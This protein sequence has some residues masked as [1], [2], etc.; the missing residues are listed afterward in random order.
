MDQQKDDLEKQLKQNEIKAYEQDANGPEHEQHSSIYKIVLIVLLVLMACISLTCIYFYF[1]NKGAEGAQGQA[2]LVERFRGIYDTVTGAAQAAENQ[3][4]DAP[5]PP[6]EQMEETISDT[7]AKMSFQ[8]KATFGVLAVIIVLLLIGVVVAVGV[9][10]GR[11]TPE[12]TKPAKPTASKP[13]NSTKPTKDRPTTTPKVEIPNDPINISVPSTFQEYLLWT[14]LIVYYLIALFISLYGAVKGEPLWGMTLVGWLLVLVP[15]VLVFKF[16]CKKLLELQLT[17]AQVLISTRNP[18]LCGVGKNRNQ[19]GFRVFMSCVYSLAC[20]LMLP[21]M[22]VYLVLMASREV[23]LKLATLI[24]Q[25]Q[26][27]D[28]AGFGEAFDDVSQFFKIGYK[29]FTNGS[30]GHVMRALSRF[31]KAEFREMAKRQANPNTPRI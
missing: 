7:F 26:L 31:P 29:A 3:M 28:K 1:G 23:A 15:I 21:F 9:M 30:H 24:S 11:Q 13:K 14:A 4:D 12:Y 5:P 19:R 16:L 22:V 27:C 6:T 17:I 8:T 25:Q 10:S 2:L 18:I 20:L